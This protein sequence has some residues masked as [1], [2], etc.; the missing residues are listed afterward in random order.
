MTHS[1]VG[2]SPARDAGRRLDLTSPFTLVVLFLVERLLFEE[3]PD[4]RIAALC[5]FDD[6]ASLSESECRS[7]AGK[8]EEWLGEHG[9]EYLAWHIE[10]DCADRIP[11]HLVSVFV[12]E[13]LVALQRFLL[14]CGG[15]RAR[16]EPDPVR[17]FRRGGAT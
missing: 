3:V 10:E 8:I 6:G 7:L 11:S 13:Q 2:I 9:C 12:R 17:A 1:F 15:L 4:G 14:H 5:R 16:R